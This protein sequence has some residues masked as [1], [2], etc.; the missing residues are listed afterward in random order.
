MCNIHKE[1]PP[2]PQPVVVQTPT[3]IV[4]VEEVK[5]PVREVVDGVTSYSYSELRAPGP[6]PAGINSDRREVYLSD[7]EFRSLFGVDKKAFESQPKWK[8]VSK[9]RELL[10]F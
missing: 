8:Q 4:V 7:N 2:Q 6:Y 3:P 1:R 9:K 10:L 5:T